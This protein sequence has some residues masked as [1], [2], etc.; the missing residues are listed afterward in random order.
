MPTALP[1]HFNTMN[2]KWENDVACIEDKRCMS[3]FCQSMLIVIVIGNDIRLRNTMAI[4][5]CPAKRFSVFLRGTKQVTNYACSVKKKSSISVVSPCDH[6]LST[7][8]Y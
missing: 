8:I 5:L 7:M 4:L 2:Q 6:R 3:N 1:V